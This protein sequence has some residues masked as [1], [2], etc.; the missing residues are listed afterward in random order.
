MLFM[1]NGCTDGGRRQERERNWLCCGPIDFEEEEK[2]V[3]SEQT[4][5]KCQK[6]KKHGGKKPKTFYQMW[7]DVWFPLSLLWLWLLLY[8]LLF[9]EPLV[10]EGLDNWRLQG[11]IRFHVALCLPPLPPSL[12]WMPF[13]NILPSVISLLCHLISLSLSP[14]P[15]LSLCLPLPLSAIQPGAHPTI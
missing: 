3:L 1:E 6:K 13:G 7:R 9:V 12:L 5:V 10:A 4:F 15:F 8:C 11:K 14:W 2:S